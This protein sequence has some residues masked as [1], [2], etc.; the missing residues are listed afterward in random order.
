MNI[1][2]KIVEVWPDDHLMVARYWTDILTEEML[3]GDVNRNPDGTPV[4]CR[5]DVAINIPIPVPSEEELDVFI[6][7]N[8]PLG[9]LKMMEDVKNPDVDTDVSHVSSL[10][11]VTKTTTVSEIEEINKPL[12]PD[13]IVP[14][15]TSVELTET[16]I[17][18]LINSLKK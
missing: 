3:A 14:A 10:L 11:R 16:D 6:K 1:H 13:S 18:N 9:W 4:R 15:A 7:K 8:A 12:I 17:Q 2:Y 5:T